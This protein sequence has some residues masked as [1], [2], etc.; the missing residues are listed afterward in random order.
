MYDH[1]VLMLGS[2][3]ACLFFCMISCI[4]LA[5]FTCSVISG[6]E[7]SVIGVHPFPVM[8]LCNSLCSSCLIYQYVY[9]MRMDSRVESVFKRRV[10]TIYP[11]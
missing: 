3:G 4:P 9:C 5:M 11:R 7:C 1:Y 8:N 6:E 2:L 10:A